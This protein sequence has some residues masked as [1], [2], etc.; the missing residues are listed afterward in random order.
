LTEQGLEATTQAYN[1]N[2]AVDWQE[3]LGTP[4]EYL[5]SPN[6]EALESVKRL[7]FAKSAVTSI[8]NTVFMYIMSYLASRIEEAMGALSITTDKHVTPIIGSLPT[9]YVNAQATKL[10]NEVL[11]VFDQGTFGYINYFRHVI[12]TLS[13]QRHQQ[14]AIRAEDIVNKL[15]YAYLIRGNPHWSGLSGK[16]TP[17]PPLYEHVSVGHFLEPA[18]LFMMGHEYAH[19]IHGHHDSDHS[20]PA[21]IA[22]ETFNV[23]NKSWE[24]EFEADLRGLQLAIQ[25]S[26][27]HNPLGMFYVYSGIDYLFHTLIFAERALSVVMNGDESLKMQDANHPPLYLRQLILREAITRSLDDQAISHVVQLAMLN[28]QLFGPIWAD[29]Q[30]FLLQLHRDGIQPASIWNGRM[31]ANENA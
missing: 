3:R 6:P 17:L 16:T 20:Q 29:A 4:P 25:A 11:V 30:P 10:G 26:S 22:G 7:F 8:Q 13:L 9:G 2:L 14:V 19:I 31:T 27:G 21:V 1:E 15:M 18:L 5:S 23:M 12:P 28:Q 24:Q